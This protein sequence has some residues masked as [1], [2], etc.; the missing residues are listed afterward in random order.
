MYGEMEMIRL[1]SEYVGGEWKTTDKVA[2]SSGK[3]SYSRSS[4][5]LTPPFSYSTINRFGPKY[6]GA[7]PHTLGATCLTVWSK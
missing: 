4:Y 2:L 7:K 5:F 6:L 1:R 3:R